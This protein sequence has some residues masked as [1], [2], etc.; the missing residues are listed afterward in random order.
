MTKFIIVTGD[1][2]DGDYISRATKI[3][4]E[5]LKEIRPVIEVLRKE[6]KDRDGYNWATYDSADP[7]PYKKYKDILTDMQ[8]EMFNEFV[9]H[10][11]NGISSIS[12][13]KIL[14]V[15]NIEEIII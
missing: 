2:N 1:E 10:G 8:I 14:T 7:D 15:T 11:E 9:P 3:T 4:E 5:E 12:E 6:G 13:L